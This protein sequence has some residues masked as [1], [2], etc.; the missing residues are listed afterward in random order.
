MNIA[1]NDELSRIVRRLRNDTPFRESGDW[2]SVAEVTAALPLYADMG[3]FLTI[4]EDGEI[5]RYDPE[6]ATTRPEDDERWRL[7][8]RLAAADRFPELESLRPG[9][10]SDARTC[11]PCAGAGRVLEG[12]VRCGTCFGL[13]WLIA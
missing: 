4:R 9:R 1:W 10:P 8:A 6:T 5:L 12:T 7:V 11:S 3:G 2:K 13:G